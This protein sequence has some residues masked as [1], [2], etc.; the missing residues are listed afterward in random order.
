LEVDFRRYRNL[1][2]C[3]PPFA[4]KALQAEDKIRTLLPCNVIIQE[5]ALNRIKLA[6]E[7]PI[8][9]LI[10]IYNLALGS[11]AKELIT[12]LQSIINERQ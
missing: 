6:A 5:F 12:K 8:A 3:N 7:N 9:S 10:A 11:I 2:A 4:F 1:G